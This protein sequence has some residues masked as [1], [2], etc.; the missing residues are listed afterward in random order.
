MK[1]GIIPSSPEG[2]ELT[3]SSP[4]RLRYAKVRLKSANME[5]DPE[6]PSW[7]S[8]GNSRSM[9]SSIWLIAFAEPTPFGEIVATGATIIV[10]GIILYE[11]IGSYTNADATTNPNLAHCLRIY[12]RCTGQTPQHDCST[13]MQFCN[14]QG[15]WDTYNCPF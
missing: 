10:G 7:W 15:H 1:E 9:L 12:I 8:S 6:R 13:C 2:D 5:D 14:A 3:I 11:F 4:A